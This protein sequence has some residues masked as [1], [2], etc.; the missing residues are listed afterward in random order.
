MKKVVIGLKQGDVQTA[1]EFAAARRDQKESMDKYEE[2]GGVKAERA[3]N[4][5]Y[6]GALA[7]I[8]IYRFLKRLGLK[9]KAPDFSIHAVQA[10]RHDPD[11][12]DNQGNTFHCKGQPPKSKAAFGIGWVYNKN[13]SLFKNYTNKD[14]AVLSTVN[15]DDLEVEIYGVVKIED[16][17]K[18]DLLR[19]P[20]STSPYIQASKVKLDWN[21]VK[22]LSWYERWGRLKKS[23]MV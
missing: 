17:V 7:E 22:T 8:A 16:I 18:K 15:P 10:K 3:E 9:V 13:Y 2:R 5:C 4:D 6:I 1:R 19:S 23:I 14:Y 12:S 20:D 11:L 21:E